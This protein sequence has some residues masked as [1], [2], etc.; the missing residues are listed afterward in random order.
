MLTLECSTSYIYDSFNRRLSKTENGRKTDYLYHGQNEIG[1]IV[2]GEVKELRILGNGHG[3]EVG[4]A[5]A[6]ELDGNILTP[7]HDSFGNVIA[8]LDTE[9][10][11]VES[12]RYTSLE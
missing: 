7:V 8:L 2:D 3:A 4:A 12:Y 6:L 9:G 5:I 10:H 11:L 1:A